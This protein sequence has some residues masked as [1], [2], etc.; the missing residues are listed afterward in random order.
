M[1]RTLKRTLLVS[2]IALALS[3]PAT[4]QFNNMYFFGDSLTDAGTYG[5]ARFTINPGLVWAQ[6]LGNTYNFK[7]TPS[8]AGGTDYAQGGARVT[9]PSSSIIPGFAQRPV[10]TQIDELLKATPNLNPGALYSV[11]IGAN[12]LQQILAAAGAGQ[13]TQAD[14]ASQTA[15][16]ATQTAQQLARLNA[17]GARFIVV[18]NLPD[19]GKTPG[20][21]AAGPANA[22]AASQ[23][24]GLFNSTL[25]ASTAKLGFQIIPVNIFALFNEVLASPSTYGFL[26]TTGV[27]CTTASALTCTTS[28]LVSPNAASTYLFADAIHP[29]PA[30]HAI[31]AQVVNS[32]IT[33]PMEIAT[34]A[35]AP[36]SV[37]DANFRALDG[38]MWSSL[39]TPRAQGKFQGW[40]AYDY[41]HTDLNAG[42]QNG[43]ANENSIVV[44][45]DMKISDKMLV[46]LMGGY[47]ENKG[48]FGGPGGG[49]KLK[50][51]T[52]T[53]Y[54]GYG[55]GPWYFGG[56]VGGGGLDYTDINRAI[57]LGPSVRTES[58][59]TRGSEFT[60]R[61]LGGYWFN[62]QDLLHGPY[63]RVTYTKATVKSFAENGSDST[64]LLYNEQSQ[65]E[66]LWSLGWQVA[67]QIGTVRPFA[68]VTWEYDSLNNDRSVTASSVTLPGSYSIP[69]PKPDNNYA[70]FNFGASTDFGGVTGYI[71]GSTTA[72]KS[73]GNYW[74]ITVGVRVPM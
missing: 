44:G 20:G 6:D 42:P 16:A 12:D 48:D 14:A 53:L 4:A 32:M 25:A 43:H 73:D 51:P 3:T 46:G 65:K 70:L 35:E 19:L 36:F 41:S 8:N 61:L 17:A 56:T 21:Q 29:T 31:I 27:A 64:A 71:T 9:L 28:T 11:W 18:A 15:L 69:A 68:R 67:G 24:T 37:E 58:G 34:L 22:A 66:L 47:T 2:A 60:G 57:Q 1:M 54:A 50:Q 38:R 45:G 49:Y 72:G 63:A 40:A 13:I 74:A 33:G 59:Q 55:E 23:L 10:S 5:G 30:A 26:N 62:V 39:N 52:G 7:I